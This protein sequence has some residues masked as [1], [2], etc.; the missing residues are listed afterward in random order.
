MMLSKMLV[1][2]LVFHCLLVDGMDLNIKQSIKTA[3]DSYSSM[4]STKDNDAFCE[5]YVDTLDKVKEALINVKRLLVGSDSEEEDREIGGDENLER[6]CSL[7][8]NYELLLEDLYTLS[9]EG[10]YGKRFNELR[11]EE[12]T[13][14][15]YEL[16]K[17][18]NQ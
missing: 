2:L 15:F 4:A 14:S 10:K 13:S 9:A 1:F 3:R 18:V 17:E 8:S 6:E 16:R 12:G 5:Q 7:Q 11:G